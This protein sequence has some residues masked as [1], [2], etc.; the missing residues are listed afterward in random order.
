[1]GDSFI[2]ESF[3]SKVRTL[4]PPYLVKLLHTEL[5]V[6]PGVVNIPMPEVILDD[7]EVIPIVHHA[8]AAPVA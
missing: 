2:L 6:L 1:M 3:T 5:C 4:I 8:I 7:G